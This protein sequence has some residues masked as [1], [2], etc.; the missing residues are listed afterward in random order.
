MTKEL[1]AYLQKMED[2]YGSP[3]TDNPDESGYLTP[4]GEFIRMGTDGSRGEDHRGVAYLT[5][6]EDEMGSRWPSVVEWMKRTGCI[7]WMPESCSFDLYVKPT[8]AQIDVMLEMTKRHCDDGIDVELTKKGDHDNAHFTHRG[9]SKLRKFVTE[10]WT[11]KSFE[12]NPKYRIRWLMADKETHLRDLVNDKS[13]KS[14][15]KSGFIL[16]SAGGPELVWWGFGKNVL[17]VRPSSKD[18]LTY[19]APDSPTNVEILSQIAKEI[20]EWLD[21]HVGELLYRK[22]NDEIVFSDTGLTLS[23]FTGEVSCISGSFKHK[24]SRNVVTD[25][26]REFLSKTNVE[27]VAWYHATLAENVPSI[28]RKGLLPPSKVSAEGW[29]PSWNWEK[30]DAV[31]LTSSL[32]YASRIAETLAIGAKQD[33]VVLVVDGKALDKHSLIVD[34]DAIRNSDDGSANYGEIDVDFPDYITSWYSPIQSIASLKAVR[35]K[36]ISVGVTGRFVEESYEY[37]GEDQVE[38]SVEFSGQLASDLAELASEE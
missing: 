14:L 23:E 33:A 16:N 29:S 31:Y 22:G 5:P 9:A 1:K 36:F 3:F 38:E 21:Y 27:D 4:D 17:F 32:L 6:V 12:Q 28:M 11:A 13:M 24:S 26:K 18:I 35:P 10:F 30:Q 19:S 2:G 37:R 34:E 25:E 7:R 15:M 8:K 20:P